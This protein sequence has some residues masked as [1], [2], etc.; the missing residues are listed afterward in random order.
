MIAIL[1]VCLAVSSSILIVAFA[2]NRIRGVPITASMPP[3]LRNVARFAGGPF[4]ISIAIHLAIILALVVAVHESR[5]REL[6]ILM[7]DPGSFHP[8]E[9]AEPLEI[10]DVPMPEFNTK[11][12]DDSPPVVDVKKV[13]GANS[14]DLAATP[15][16]TGLD[17]GHRHFGDYL[18]LHP[19]LRRRRWRE[20]SMVRRPA[21]P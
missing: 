4:S 3:G 9:D 8:L 2:W 16:D 5:A 12:P 11:S 10:P 19:G 1:V 7:M 17:L 20:L 21:A 15:S 18:N 14:S 6:L 13:L